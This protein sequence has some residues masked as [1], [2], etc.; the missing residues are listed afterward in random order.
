MEPIPTRTSI[1]ACRFPH[2][3]L[4]VA[5]ATQSDFT[6]NLHS[7]AAG[8]MLLVLLGL[9][10]TAAFLVQLQ[11]VLTTK[12]HRDIVE[13]VR[14]QSRDP[15]NGGRNSFVSLITDQLYSEC[16]ETMKVEKM[17]SS[18]LCGGTYRVQQSY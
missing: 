16:S 8:R 15:L 17:C 3:H 5:Q 6:R 12:F 11:G 2:C 18:G 1:P 10:F 4:C 9:A 13:G 14:C 7:S